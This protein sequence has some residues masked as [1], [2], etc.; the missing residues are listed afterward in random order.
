LNGDLCWFDEISSATYAQ[1]A[2]DTLQMA[3]RVGDP[4]FIITTTPK[5]MPL[6]QSFFKAAKEEGSYIKITRG[7]TFDNPH[8]NAKTKA[9]LA[10][11]YKSTTL[12]R[13]ELEGELLEED[14][15]PLFSYEIIDKNR[16]DS[17]PN[18]I[19]TVVAV[20]PAVTTY[21]SSDLT[22][23]IVAG[24]GEDR[25]VYVLEDKSGKY[26]P[27]KWA[28]IACSLYHQYKCSYVILESNQGGNLLSSNINNF[29]PSVRTK[30]IHATVG[31]AVRFEPVVSVYQQGKVHHAKVFPALED[32]MITYNPALKNQKSPDR[33]DALAYT[34]H[35]LLLSAQLAYRNAEW[36]GYF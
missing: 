23:I 14:Q 32:Q 18:L 30:L 8:L 36:A 27:A 11:R 33:A 12:G 7:S 21:Q 25:H 24:L 3:I 4:R 26:G 29:D 9:H 35:D 13:Q 1:E 20:D 31:K 5:P 34:V 22:G 10:D 15:G 28:E 16:V 2:W 6:M 19:R 17:V